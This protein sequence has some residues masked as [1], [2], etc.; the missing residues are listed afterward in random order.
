MKRAKC[1]SSIQSSARARSRPE[2]SHPIASTSPDV[3]AALPLINTRA[4]QSPFLAAGVPSLAKQ[5]LGL[6]KNK[7]LP[8]S[9]SPAVA[10]VNDGEPLSDIA[11]CEMTSDIL[12]NVINCLAG[13]VA[14]LSAAACVNRSWKANAMRPCLWT[15]LRFSTQRDLA[16]RLSDANLKMLVQRA[17][18]GLRSLD[19]ADSGKMKITVLGVMSALQNAPLLYKLGVRG[20]LYGERN[21]QPFITRFDELSA[22]IRPGDGQLDVQELDGNELALCVC[23]MDDGTPNGGVCLRLC[24]AQDLL[25]AEC[26]IFYCPDCTRTSRQDH[27]PPCP[28]LCDSC[29]R[30]CA[31]D[32][33]SH[34][35]LCDASGEMSNGC[36]P[37]CL[38]LCGA[39]N[40]RY[41][42]GCADN[43][44]FSCNGAGPHSSSTNLCEPCVFPTASHRHNQQRYLIWC[45]CCELLL[46]PLCMER[47]DV[48][49]N[50]PRDP[51]PPSS[52]K[53]E[54]EFCAC[55]RREVMEQVDGIWLCYGCAI[56]AQT[57]PEEEQAVPEE[58][59]AP[60]E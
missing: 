5:R 52:C 58:P 17:G 27:S 50:E 36:C 8:Q 7:M 32:A 51:L 59:Q 31:P 28:H 53:C 57:S 37:E 34:C 22:L 24:S 12:F 60:Q 43:Y 46:C 33:L 18:P 14:A 44:M 3:G 38:E 10:P 56:K 21:E 55:C 35:T 20:V 40:E 45:D 19:L 47:A 54:K 25:C 41:C 23:E 49:D 4:S 11:A 15:E 6:S 30:R 42:S 16:L 48:S 13:D 2:R 26:G 1:N 39:C 29:L 9:S